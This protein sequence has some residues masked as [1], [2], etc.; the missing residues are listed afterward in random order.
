MRTL[1]QLQVGEFARVVSI[2][3]G[4][5]MLQRLMS[6][7]VS[8]RTEVE[9]LHHRGRGVVVGVNGNRV[10]IGGGVAEHILLQTVSPQAAQDEK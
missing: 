3:G 6:L 7:G 9:V 1:T 5:N 10:A 4:R 2:N 8:V